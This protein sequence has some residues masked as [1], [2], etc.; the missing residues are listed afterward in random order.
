MIA[1]TIQNEW[2]YVGVAWGVTAAVIG[3]YTVAVMR[4][5]RELAKRVPEERRRWM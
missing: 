2:A 4:R 3:T 1:S 5:G